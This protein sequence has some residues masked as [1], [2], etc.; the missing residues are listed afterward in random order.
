MRQASRVSGVIQVMSASAL[1]V[2]Q[3]PLKKVG[4]NLCRVEDSP[5]Q[6]QSIYS[7]KLNLW[8]LVSTQI[9]LNVNESMVKHTC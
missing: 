3:A 6:F 4:W 2:S 9:A 5:F 8:R 1:A 7:N